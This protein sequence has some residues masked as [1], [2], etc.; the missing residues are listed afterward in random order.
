MTVSSKAPATSNSNAY[1]WTTVRG[2]RTIEWEYM[3]TN[4]PKTK[5][6]E[7]KKLKERVESENKDIINLSKRRAGKVQ[8]Y[9]SIVV[10]TDTLELWSTALQRVIGGEKRAHFSTVTT[11]T[12]TKITFST[13]PDEYRV[14]FLNATLYFNTDTIL[15]QPGDGGEDDLLSFIGSYYN[16]II[17]TIENMKTENRIAGT[18]RSSPSTS[19][20]KSRSTSSTT[21]PALQSTSATIVPPAHNNDSLPTSTEPLIRVN[22][23]LCYVSH[24]MKRDMTEVIVS[25]CCEFYSA[26]YNSKEKI[27]AIYRN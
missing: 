11:G 25:A 22:E 18:S 17:S 12:Q 3:P 21:T 26:R 7:R 1:Q 16:K 6:Q 4:T 20:Q 13:T 10:V 24:R 2:V 5:K 9:C 15:I 27:S 19:N 8:E 23:L 14:I